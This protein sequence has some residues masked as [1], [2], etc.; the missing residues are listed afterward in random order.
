MYMPAPK[1]ELAMIG[2]IQWTDGKDVHA[3][4]KSLLKELVSFSPSPVYR[5][6][7]MATHD[8]GSKK[9]PNR[10]CHIL[11]SGTPLPSFALTRRR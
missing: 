4:Q 9:A 5:N 1:S 8:M 3:N 6:S 2:T 7:P 10:A 11:A